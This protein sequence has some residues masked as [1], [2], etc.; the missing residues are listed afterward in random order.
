ME[1][2]YSMYINTHTRET[3]EKSICDYLS[4]EARELLEVFSKAPYINAFLDIDEFMEAIDNFLLQH[5]PKKQINEI[6]FFHLTRRLISSNDDVTGYN[7][8]NLLTT[9]NTISSF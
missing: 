7:L 4:I 6:L 8:V 3:M 9:D 5:K 1:E 2:Y